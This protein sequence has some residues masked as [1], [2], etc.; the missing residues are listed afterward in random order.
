MTRSG[1]FLTWIAKTNNELHR[2]QEMMCL[3]IKKEKPAGPITPAGY[4]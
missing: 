4:V 3:F 2:E 1:V